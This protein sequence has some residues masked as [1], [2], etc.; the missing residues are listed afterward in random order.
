MS[1]RSRGEMDHH[2]GLRNKNSGFELQ[3]EQQF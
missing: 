2:D 3:G 1:S